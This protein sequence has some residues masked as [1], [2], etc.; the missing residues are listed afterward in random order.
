MTPQDLEE[1]TA[2]SVSAFKARRGGWQ[3]PAAAVVAVAVGGVLGEGGRAAA[4][5]AAF[6]ALALA[7]ADYA[8][9]GGAAVETVSG[10]VFPGACVAIICV[11]VC[12][13]VC[14]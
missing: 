6:G 2:L 10:L 5:V 11:C 8:L 7:G 1:D 4:T 12:V 14:V 9:T 13:C 3:T